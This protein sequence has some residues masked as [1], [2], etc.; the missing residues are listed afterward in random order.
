[1]DLGTIVPGHGSVCKKDYLEEQADI[2]RQWVEVVKSAIDR[3]LDEEEAVA[4]ISCP[5]P[6]P[7]D[8]KKPYSAEYLNK[9]IITRLYQLYTQ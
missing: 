4:G 2:I 5:D 3:G 9:L 1:M 7:A 6:Y 8:P